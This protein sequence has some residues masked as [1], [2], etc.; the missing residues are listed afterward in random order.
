MAVTTY[1]RHANQFYPHRAP[2]AAKPF[3]RNTFSS[4][5]GGPNVPPAAA[6]DFE[7]FHRRSRKGG[8]QT[9]SVS[10]DLRIPVAD[11]KTS[12]PSLGFFFDDESPAEVGNFIWTSKS[13]RD[14][15]RTVGTLD[16]GK[17]PNPITLRYSP[18]RQ[19]TYSELA[20]NDDNKFYHDFSLLRRPWSDPKLRWGHNISGRIQRRSCRRSARGAMKLVDLR[21]NAVP[22]F[23]L[24]EDVLTNHF[25]RLG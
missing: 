13:T 17:D 7:T 3:G 15:T 20:I 11:S 21:A 16:C 12:A 2:P 14:D 18:R 24:Q 9:L 8:A 19:N 4:M 5:Q 25:L 6:A 10:T 1:E 22:R 23:G